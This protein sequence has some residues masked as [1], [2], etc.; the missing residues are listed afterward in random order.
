MVRRAGDEVASWFGDEDAARRRE[1][2][3]RG[4]GPAGYT[5]SDERIREDAND[6]LTEDWRVDA[7]RSRSR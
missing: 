3:H 4:K 1:Q 2:D 7:S 5:R 6:T